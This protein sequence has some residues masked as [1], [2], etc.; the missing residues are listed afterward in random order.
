MKTIEG[1][2]NARHT[3][4]DDSCEP[5]NVEILL[6]NITNAFENTCLYETGKVAVSARV[7]GSD[8]RWRRIFH[9][10]KP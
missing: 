10:R 7:I 5:E 3:H 8:V 1:Y 4:W 6:V 9:A 2:F